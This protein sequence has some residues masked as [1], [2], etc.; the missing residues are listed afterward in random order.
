MNL[1]HKRRRRRHASE[2]VPTESRG[3]YPACI[4]EQI[5][6]KG[7]ARVM[8]I[9][10]SLSVTEPSA[11]ALIRQLAKNGYVKRENTEDLQAEDPDGISSIAGASTESNYQGCTR[12]ET[13]CQHSLVPASPGVSAFGRIAQLNVRTAT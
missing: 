2:M 9:A 1:E 8:D 13:H 6:N 5:G 7:Y 11:S 4:F 3:D 12:R 10:V